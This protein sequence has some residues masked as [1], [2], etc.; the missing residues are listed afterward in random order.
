MAISG[1]FSANGS[2]DYAFLQYG[3]GFLLFDATAGNGFGGGTLT[4]QIKNTAGTAVTVYAYTVTPS[5][6]PV[7]IDLGAP[8]QVRVTL[9]GSTSPTLYYEI[10]EGRTP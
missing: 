5:P 9:S 10:N 1:T 4:L 6:N 8:G 2:S 3:K 7:G